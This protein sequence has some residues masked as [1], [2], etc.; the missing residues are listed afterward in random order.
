MTDSEAR[1]VSLDKAGARDE[2]GMAAWSVWRLLVPYHKVQSVSVVG[3]QTQVDGRWGEQPL[4]Y[5]FTDAEL[6][7]QAPPGSDYA[8]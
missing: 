1:T 7:D 4:A 8:R 3:V 2:A 5:R 6:R